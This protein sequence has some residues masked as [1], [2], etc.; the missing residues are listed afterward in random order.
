MNKEEIIKG[1]FARMYIHGDFSILDRINKGK[2]KKRNDKKIALKKIEE[3]TEIKDILPGAYAAGEKDLEN[4]NIELLALD[5][6]EEKGPYFKEELIKY[7]KAVDIYKNEILAIK[8]ECSLDLNIADLMQKTAYNN[9]GHLSPPFPKEDIAKKYPEIYAYYESKVGI[10]KRI[11]LF[12]ERKNLLTEE[13]N[14]KA[15]TRE[16]VINGF[17]KKG[18]TNYF[19]YLCLTLRPNRSGEYWYLHLAHIPEERKYI[20][21]KIKQAKKDMPYNKKIISKYESIK[22]EYI[23]LADRV[24]E[25][26][27]KINIW[28][29]KRDKGKKAIPR[30][31]QAEERFLE[32]V[33]DNL[34]FN[35][36]KKYENYYGKSEYLGEV[37][38]QPKKKVTKKVDEEQE[39]KP[40]I[41][42]IRNFLNTASDK[43]IRKFREG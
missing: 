36:R 3:L 9:L 15:L 41:E 2:E 30:L 20:E 19:D 25:V 37:Y 34:I 17:S 7:K 16:E 26:R 5:E 33:K 10:E 6:I 27:E 13:G 1:Y 8:N 29:D 11:E 18:I 12:D 31:K 4:I 23:N 32:N 22:K 42:D 40:S 39:K 35:N 14:P 43:E 21:K 28:N 24:N 38:L